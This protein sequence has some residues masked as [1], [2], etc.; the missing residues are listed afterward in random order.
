MMPFPRAAGIL[1]H[2]TSL[3]G[4]FGCGDLGAEAHRWV[5]CLATMRQRLW[6]V[7]PLG[8]TGY[9]DSPYQAFST[10]AGNPLVVSLPWLTDVGLL[11]GDD[12]DRF[13]PLPADR[14]DFGAVIPAR[15]AILDRAC[16]RW[17]RAAPGALVRAEEAFAERERGWLDDWC[18]FAALKRRFGGAPW[19]DWPADLVAREPAALRLARHRLAAEVAHA[20]LLQFFFD[21]QWQRLRDRCRSLGIALVGDLPIF[22][23]HDS[24]DVWCH[25][26]LFHLD[27]GG[28]PTV[29]AGV[30]PDYFAVDGQ[31]W[32]NPLYRWERHAAD[33]FAWWVRRL[34]SAFERHDV[35]RIDHFRG[36][37]AAWEIP[38]DAP[39]AAT[40]RWVEGPG[41][42]LFDAA[43]RTLGDR[44]IIAED[45]GLIT[46]DVEAL[47]LELGFPG[48]RVLQFVFG[49]PPD[50]TAPTTDD[51][52]PDR[53]VYT[54]THDNDTAR[55]WYDAP[56]DANPT[57]TA[58]AVE[59]ERHR[60]RVRLS[61]DGS[62]IHWDLI[63]M[64]LASRTHTAIY[65]LQDLLGLGS[66]ARMNVPGR[67]WG[68]WTW[69]FRWETLTPEIMTRIAALTTASGRG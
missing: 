12:L 61:A 2:P 21:E 8:P 32:G 27:A 33:G 3:P 14:V 48:M 53:V 11:D 22:V 17:P 43:R 50:P 25:R 65:P 38:A 54:G 35:V 9:G 63:G 47:R 20:R 60:A 68:N 39:T 26:E 30:P 51:D 66:E 67:P 24:A 56:A 34:H 28:R 10:F 44:P 55:G 6:Q 40:G 46:A 4:R 13:P 23:A 41:R 15:A 29:V 42:T 7:L 36:F 18:L 52:P 19:V 59:R 64:A 69:R 37:A 58:D 1:L 5:E 45:L 31:R 49:D 62:Q 57:R 16:D